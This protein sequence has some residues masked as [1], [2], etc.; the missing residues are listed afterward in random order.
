MGKKWGKNGEK[1]EPLF[2]FIY[3]LLFIKTIHTKTI[4]H[5]IHNYHRCSV[6]LLNLYHQ[7]Q[8]CPCH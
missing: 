1:R 4:P 7:L 5:N 2:N 3:Y 6:H 8:L